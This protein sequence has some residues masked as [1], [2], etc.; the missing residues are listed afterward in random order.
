M[1]LMMALARSTSSQYPFS[2]VRKVRPGGAAGDV[3]QAEE[4][5]EVVALT[6]AIDVAKHSGMVRTRVPH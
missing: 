1:P 5:V 4:R 2:T 3:E 6:A